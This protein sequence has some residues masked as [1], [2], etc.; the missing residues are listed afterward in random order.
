MDI[1]GLYR[2]FSQSSISIKLVTLAVGIVWGMVLVAFIAVTILLLEQPT[3]T[4][5]PTPGGPTPVITLDPA[6]GPPGTTVGVRG[7]G[8]NPGDVVLIYLM[9]PGETELPS[10]AVA[11]LNAD[12]QG[13]FAVSIVVPAE[14]GWENQ[15][16][17]TIVAQIAE[18]GT[19]AQAFFSVLSMPIEP[20]P[21]SVISIEPTATPTEELPA[22]P[23]AT[24]QPKDPMATAST[25]VNIRSGPGIAYSVL[26]VLRSGQQAKIT[27]ISTDSSWWQ[28]EF[29]GAASE[30]GWLSAKYVTTQDMQD[31]P[32]V[33][34]PSL[35]ATPTP[36]PTPTPT[37]TSTPV[38]ITAWR[39][40][41]YNN[42]NLSGAPVFVRN[43]VAISFD[44][45]T[46]SPGSGLPADDFSARW[47]RGLSFSAG[48]Y[49]FHARVDDGIRLWLDGKLLID[50][51]HDSAPTTYIADASLSQG[52]HSIWVEY[53]E[54]SGGALAQLSWERIEE[55][56][57][58]WK[59]EY[60][61]NRKLEG[62][63]VLVRN[64]TEIDHNWGSGSPGHG[65][66][67]DD[68]SARWTREVDFRS[69]TYV[70]R[71]R[72][73]DGVRLW[74]EDKLVIDSWK[75]GSAR[76]V[77]AE[78]RI[79]RGEHQVEVE[80]Y[81][82]SG[83]ARIEVEWERKQESDNQ[84]PQAIPGGPYSLDEGGQIAF[85]GRGS[86]D[87]DGN[88]VKYEWDFNYDG[89]SFVADAVGQT[90]TTSYPDGPKKVTAALRVT[91][92]KGASHT[93]TVQVQ[94]QNVAP[95]AEAGG[96]YTGQVGAIISLAGTATDPG[97]IDQAGLNY[98]WDF[99]DG[100]KG[101][102]PIV[103]HSYTQPGNY[104]ATLTVTDK[105]GAHVTDAAA[106]Q[107]V[108]ANQ[109]PTA[110]I[111]GPASGLVGDTLSFSASGSY[112][113]DGSIEGY[114]WNFGDGTTSNQAEP[115]HTYNQ[116]GSY[117]VTLTVT[118]NGG[119]T[120]QTT[121]TIQ[122]EEP[123]P[124]NQ[125]PTAVISGPASGLVG[126]PL[127]FDAS[128]SSDSDGSIIDYAWA[129]GDGAVG[130]GI[131]VTHVY[132]QAG[133]YQLALT[134]TDDG[135]LTAGTINTIQVEANNSSHK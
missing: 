121:H 48:T 103:G 1:E 8:W 94:V 15:G 89:R 60:Y 22:T 86:K 34:A 78:Y 50:E 61:D 77:E 106:V 83:G 68:F 33:Q 79:N 40:E 87:P 42:P 30:R 59:A 85:N 75:D 26:G 11:G 57:P 99:G 128:G 64:E 36:Q 98:T 124:A 91:D 55:Q 74:V 45:G 112:D 63:P 93:V 49:R 14:P 25:D 73:D 31:I 17:A 69:E 71:V 135:G 43:D 101:S 76:W 100:T 117:Q 120:D 107:V 127:S 51:W 108:A 10:Y 92:D 109:S 28:I 105:D 24:P 56:Y 115:S 19:A 81:E 111:S 41:Y 20:T 18:T 134:V 16:V 35:P 47:S 113:N 110:V 133:S 88:I 7:E 58:D 66:P 102:G 13:Q 21:T 119:L 95:T 44:W 123:A 54:R 12:T 130:S 3:H 70:F 46:G 4:L 82:H 125:S 6:V 97:S 62:K 96:P 90:V 65:V 9:A 80:Y 126:E 129:F 132:T 52:T 114:A 5:T 32:V 53:Y 2:K 72:V 67:E 84:P 29:S 37:P 23:T 104:T 116:A 118:D 39:G 131:T 38:V 27:G 122:I